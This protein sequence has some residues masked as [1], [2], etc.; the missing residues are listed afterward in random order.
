M[1]SD[2]LFSAWRLAHPPGLGSDGRPHANLVP[3]EGKTLFETLDQSGL[4]DQR[5]YIVARSAF[6]FTILNV[7]PY[8]S[9]HVMVLPRRAVRSMDELTEDAFVDLW[10][11]V[12]AASGAVKKAFVPD[13]LNIGINEG[14]AGGGSYPAHLHVHVVPRWNA[15]TNF[16]STAAETRILPMS[17]S[18]SWQRLRDAWPSSVGADPV[19]S[20]G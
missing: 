10:H 5:T 12:R 6:S 17:L 8:T 2:R 18:A 4:D 16:M 20:N 14:E 9:G 11:M 13:G 15:D 7:Y 19:A 1:S 3:A